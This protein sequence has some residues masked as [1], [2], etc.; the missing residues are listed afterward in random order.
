MEVSFPCTS[1]CWTGTDRQPCPLGAAAPYLR[2]GSVRS[3]LLAVRSGHP[4]SDG[5]VTVF[6]LEQSLSCVSV[7]PHPDHDRREML[8]L[9]M[10]VV[11]I[12]ALGDSTTAGTPG[13]R[14]PIQSPPSGA[15]HVETQYA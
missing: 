11:T 1:A 9:L 8:S 15:G 5:V 4:P 2:A 3:D 13:Y 12:V 6:R 7:V 10:S 14:S